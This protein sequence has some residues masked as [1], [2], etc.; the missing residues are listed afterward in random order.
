[1]R[2]TAVAILMLL[3]AGSAPAAQAQ[4][5]PAAGGK[6]YAVIFDF[7]CAGSDHGRALADSVRLRLRRHEEYDVLD[8]LT[9]QEA[10][11]PLGVEAQKDAIGLMGSLASNL[12][13]F[14]TVQVSGAEVRAEIRCIDKT[15]ADGTAREWTKVFTDS[16]ERYKA[17]IARQIVEAIRGQAEWVPPQYGDEEEPKDFAKPLNANGDFEAGAAAWDRPDNVSTFLEPGPAGRGTVLR[18]RTDLARDPWL[19]YKRAMMFGQAD[20]RHPPQIGRDTSYGSVAGLEGV[21]FAGD[22]IRAEPGRRYW[23]VADAKTAGGTPKVFVK[24]FRK[25]EHALDGL[26]EGALIELGLTPEQFVALPAERRRKLIEDDAAKHPMRYVRECYRWYLNLRD[27][28]AAWTHYAAPF[29]PRGGLPGDVEWLQIQ[30]YAYWPPGEY[31]FD[32]VHLYADPRQA[33]TQAVE[34]AR[35]PNFGKTSDVVERATSQPAK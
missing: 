31:L 12:A 23:L 17:E 15:A 35:T 5:A 18:I 13:V 8:R 28:D 30:V 1:V 25:T 34:P 10:S 19:E 6:V 33:A 3:S 29:P 20:P 11:R 24:G 26:P 27:G 21:H 22:W 16:T 4:S 14:G 2:R 7:A 32:N 9:T